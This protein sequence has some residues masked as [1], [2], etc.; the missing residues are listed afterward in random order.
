MNRCSAGEREGIVGR[1]SIRALL[2]AL[3]VASCLCTTSKP[4][5]EPAQTAATV[6]P[7]ALAGDWLFEMTRGGQSIQYSLHFSVT[8]GILA[9]SLTGPD[10]NAR[11]LTKIALKDDK[12]AWDIEGE[13]GTLHYEGTVSGSSMKGTIKRSANR[14]RQVSRD[15]DSN[16]GSS[17]SA[18]EG[19][20]ARA[21]GMRGSRRGH[22]G[23]GGGGG[24]QMTWSAYK[25]T[26]SAPAETGPASPA[27]T[28]SSPAI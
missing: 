5:P 11:E 3:S 20:G 9:G 22:S 14:G 16:E 24:Q 2:A 21:G 27:P 1:W 26:A 18:P 15:G 19:S 17:G 8:S 4:P 12:A 10:G 13:E 25:S 6:R 23:R 28:P 7:E